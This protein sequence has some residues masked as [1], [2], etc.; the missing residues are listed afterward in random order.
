MYESIKEHNISRNAILEQNKANLI[1]V[2]DEK[3][4]YIQGTLEEFQTKMV[5]QQAELDKKI[6][7]LGK[8]ARMTKMLITKCAQ[9]TENAQSPGLIQE[10]TQKVIENVDERLAQSKEQMNQN[11]EFFQDAID[12]RMEE[13]AEKMKSRVSDEELQTELNLFK[14][15]IR[16]K[17]PTN[18]ALQS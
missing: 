1:K 6:S 8:S 13:L 15:E 16:R 2:V 9:Q 11:L 7:E 3:V 5:S 10:Q 17:Q 12:R 18:S 4:N 14:A